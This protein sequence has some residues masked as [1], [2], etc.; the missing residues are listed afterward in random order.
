MTTTDEVHLK[1]LMMLGQICSQQQWV[2]AFAFKSSTYCLSA[3]LRNI[4]PGASLW[5]L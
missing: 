2:A 3:E 4:L 5:N 1:A